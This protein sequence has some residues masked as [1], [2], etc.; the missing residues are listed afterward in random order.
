[1]P[2]AYDRV[3][4][5]M[6]S[7]DRRHLSQFSSPKASGSRLAPAKISFFNQALAPTHQNI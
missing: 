1:M 5:P 3:D 4:T 2:P 6:V 7:A